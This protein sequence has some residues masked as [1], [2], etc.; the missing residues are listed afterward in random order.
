MIPFFIIKLKKCNS[1]IILY[2]YYVKKSECENSYMF[3]LN[4]NFFVILISK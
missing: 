1:I 2:G 4:E 3:K